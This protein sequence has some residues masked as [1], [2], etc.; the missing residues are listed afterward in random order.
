MT[1]AKV[2]LELAEATLTPRFAILYIDDAPECTIG[3]VSLA[4]RIK[5]RPALAFRA[6]MEKWTRQD[7]IREVY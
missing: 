3:V 1:D 5:A 4:L 7:T 2:L 6:I